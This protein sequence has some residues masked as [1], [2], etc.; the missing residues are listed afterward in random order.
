[1]IKKIK[2]LCLITLLLSSFSC[3]SQGIIDAN[4]D[5]IAI[6]NSSGQI[7]RPSNEII[8]E[9]VA[10]G[11]IKNSMGQVIGSIDN[12]QFKD[13]MGMILGKIDSNNNIFD[14]N[15]DMI[16]SIQFSVMVIDANNHVLGRT[17]SPINEKWSAAYFF[18][19]FNL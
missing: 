3:F 7:L 1:M 5:T 10:N 13:A 8:G 16:G 9:F 18:F 6:I 15:D 12:N 2:N 11:E 19:F 17:T 4:G 14:M